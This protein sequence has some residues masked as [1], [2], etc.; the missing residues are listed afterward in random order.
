MTRTNHKIIII[1]NDSYI[2]DGIEKKFDSSELS[3]LY[4]HNWQKNIELI[5]NSDCVINFSV[6][7]FFQTKELTEN[8]IIDV[9]IAN[10][11]KNSDTQYIFISSRK[12]YG[13]SNSLVKHKE[14]DPLVG[15]DYYSQNK[16]RAEL[17]L[18]DIMGNNVTIARVSNI[19]GKPTLRVGYKTFIG[20][21]CENYIKNKML[22][23]NQNSYS[24]KDFITTEFLQ[25]VIVS[26][27]LNRITGIY[28]VS[29]GFS[30]SVRDILQGY[31]GINS[32]QFNDDKYARTDQ[33]ILDNSKIKSE[34]K[35]DLTKDH[36]KEALKNY[37]CQ[38]I[39]LANAKTSE[40]KI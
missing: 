21:I 5:K 33:F 8:E 32:I 38:L 34:L 18:Q 16:I 37:H 14:S 20:W 36:I 31:V 23:L 30:T 39:Q 40:L 10:I 1:G 19:I 22:S 3:I 2:A 17:A 9:Q 11:L 7:P 29:A 4:Y 35:I 12:V 27:A 13:S 26:M 28:N 24:E 25:Q 6:S 15:F